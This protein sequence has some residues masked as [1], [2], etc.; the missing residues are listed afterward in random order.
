M[1]GETEWSRLKAL[2]RR[3][4][5]YIE[6]AGRPDDRTILSPGTLNG[7]EQE[8]DPENSAFGD[9]IPWHLLEERPGAGGATT[10]GLW[11]DDQG[12]AQSLGQPSGWRTPS[13]A[14]AAT[15]AGSMNH[16][17]C[18]EDALEGGDAGAD[19][20]DDW[21]HDF[22][23]DDGGMMWAQ[24]REE[25]RAWNREQEGA[26]GRP[27]RQIQLETSVR[28]VLQALKSTPSASSVEGSTVRRHQR[29][30]TE[31]WDADKE[32]TPNAV[33]WSREHAHFP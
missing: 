9:P 28:S 31:N 2:Y 27:V 15:A 13:A 21:R 11:L 33:N 1:P 5:Q 24:E 32:N 4:L 18:D 25:E 12:F 29:P 7:G 20:D 17:G 3:V 14:T 8:Q 10:R 23:D 16:D 26:E 22:H 19:D 30:L 6:Q